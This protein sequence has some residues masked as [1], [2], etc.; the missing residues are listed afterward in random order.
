MGVSSC[1]KYLDFF[2]LLSLLASLRTSQETRIAAKAT[3]L[4]ASTAA[5]ASFAA[6]GQGDRGCRARG[7]SE[8]FVVADECVHRDTAAWMSSR[9]GSLASGE[10]HEP[11]STANGRRTLPITHARIQREVSPSNH[12]RTHPCIQ[13]K[14]GIHAQHLAAGGEAS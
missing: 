3:R 14:N 2:S 11:N 13:P 6:A 5:R 9:S 10:A 7:A 8:T 4:P 12:T 1:N